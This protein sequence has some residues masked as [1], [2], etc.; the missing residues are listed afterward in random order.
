MKTSS[1]SHVTLRMTVKKKSIECCIV[2]CVRMYIVYMCMFNSVINQT[3][4]IPQHWMYCFPYV[5]DAIHSALLGGSGLINETV[6]VHTQA[7]A[8]VYVCVSKWLGELEFVSS[9]V[10]HLYIALSY[11][12]ELRIITLIG[13]AQI[14]NRPPPWLGQPTSREWYTYTCILYSI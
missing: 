10:H 4:P 14:C 8:C 12:C 7:C 11:C 6:C 1:P 2:W 5:E 9:Q 13:N 3:T